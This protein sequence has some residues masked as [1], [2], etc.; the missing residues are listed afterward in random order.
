MYLHL[1]GLD[2]PILK[3]RPRFQQTLE[4]VRKQK[5]CRRRYIILELEL[6]HCLLVRFLRPLDEIQFKLARVFFNYA[7]LL[8]LHYLRT[9][10]PSVL[11]DSLQDLVEVSSLRFMRLVLRICSALSKGLSLGPSLPWLHFMDPHCR[12]WL[13]PGLQSRASVGDG[14]SG[15]PCSSPELPCFSHFFSFRRLLLRL[16]CIGKQNSSEKPRV[17]LDG[18]ARLIDNHLCGSA[19]EQICHDHSRW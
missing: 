2:P 4:S 13:V 11:S 5:R 3:N 14:P 19:Y 1:I 17:M 16:F 18:R 6:V 10:V 7:G 9:S 8:V 12:L 15:S